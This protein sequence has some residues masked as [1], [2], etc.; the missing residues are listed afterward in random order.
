MK[1]SERFFGAFD[2]TSASPSLALNFQD[3]V[4]LFFLKFSYDLTPFA[5]LE[6]NGG[7]ISSCLAFLFLLIMLKSEMRKKISEDGLKRSRSDQA[8]L[9]ESLAT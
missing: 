9:Q 3:G 5:V 7:G 2:T 4:A 1:L 6:C 8:P